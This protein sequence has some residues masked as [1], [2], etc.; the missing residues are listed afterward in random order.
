MTTNKIKDYLPQSKSFR[1][2]AKVGF[3]DDNLTQE[4]KI[5]RNE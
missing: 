5:N 4:M 1:Y 3:L 2:L